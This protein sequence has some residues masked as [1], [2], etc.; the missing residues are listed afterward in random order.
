MPRH[1]DIYLPNF[2][3]AIKTIRYANSP[4]II[5]L[6]MEWLFNYL[7]RQRFLSL[8]GLFTHTLATKLHV[9]VT[10]NLN[11][12]TWDG[13]EW[14]TGENKMRSSEIRFEIR[15]RQKRR[16]FP[17][18]NCISSWYGWKAKKDKLDSVWDVKEIQKIEWKV[19]LLVSFES[20]LKI[21]S[22][23]NCLIFPCI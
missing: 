9:P 14:A 19:F 4:K 13:F 6:E 21:V 23:C 5:Q 10:D 15:C 22:D 12:Q 17:T 18:G 20:C 11:L 7:W 3:D 8:S 1:F 2:C 16:N